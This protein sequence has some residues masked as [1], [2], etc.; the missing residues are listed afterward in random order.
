MAQ[1]TVFVPEIG[2]LIL[3]K[4]RGATHMRLSINAA[5][6]V[7]VG[8]PYWAPYQ[9][10]IL[11]AKSKADWINKHLS[12]HTNQL[13]KDGDLIGKSHRINYVYKPAAP[14]TVRVS[15][16][17]ITVTSGLDLANANVQKKIIPSCEK[18]LRNEAE[19]LLPIRL[20]ALAREHNFE[21]KAVQI[22]KLTSRWGSCSSNK[23][24]TLSYYLMQLPWNLIDYVIVHELI[25]T[26][27]MHHGKDFWDDFK[28]ITPGARAL[29]KEIRTFRPLVQAHKIIPSSE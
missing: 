8:M 3:S 17:L 2:E 27:H 10:G 22:R 15:T 11:F 4:R 20:S 18:A 5:G 12:N 16:N 23:V 28:K 9:S 24:I 14:T 29:Q 25:H 21:Y 1:K 13:L 19:H 6:K 7:R 26:N